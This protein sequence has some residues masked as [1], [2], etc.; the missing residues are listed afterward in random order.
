MSKRFER[1]VSKPLKH[2]HRLVV[3][4]RKKFGRFKIDRIPLN[5]LLVDGT[6]QKLLPGNFCSLLTLKNT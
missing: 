6:P 3:E 5:K 2:P 4:P 1:A